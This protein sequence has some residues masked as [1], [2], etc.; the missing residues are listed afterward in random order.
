MLHSSFHICSNFVAGCREKKQ[1][2]VVGRSRSS[3]STEQ[4]TCRQY[5]VI[6]S[7]RWYR[8]RGYSTSL[9]HSQGFDSTFRT[10]RNTTPNT[11]P[12]ATHTQP[13]AQKQ[14]QHTQHFTW[15]QLLNS[16]NTHQQRRTRQKLRQPEPSLP[17][18]M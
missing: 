18:R 17:W 2:V 14:Q 12:H 6:V 4:T 16:H 3:S 1:L 15:H 10:S 11:A 5:F 8:K 9:S 7:W 13:A